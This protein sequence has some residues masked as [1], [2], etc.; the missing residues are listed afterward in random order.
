[1]PR[2]VLALVALLSNAFPVIAAEQAEA[3]FAGGC[4]WCMEPPFEQVEG[5]VSVTS[6]YTGGRKENPTYEEVSSGSTGHAEAVRVVFDPT[7]TSYEKLLDIFWHNIDPLTANRQFCDA[8]TQ[9]RS[10]IFFHDKT[11]EAAALASKAA[12]GKSG[13]L[14]DTIVTEIVPTATFYPAEDYHQDYYRKNPVRYQFYRQGC[15]RDAR[16]KEIWGSAPAH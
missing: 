10:A 4:F 8:G 5:V 2:L 3:T 15:G 13:K 1:M 9:Y 7:K 12:L 6:G 11:Q 16:L 14:K